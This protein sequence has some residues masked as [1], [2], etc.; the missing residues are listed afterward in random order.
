MKTWQTKSGYKVIQ[1]LAGRS[2]VFLLTNGEQN[3][4]VDTAENSFNG[5]ITEENKI[6]RS[7]FY[8][9]RKENHLT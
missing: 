9:F 2:N 3:I 7:H 6:F 8:C 4:L 5:T 1:V